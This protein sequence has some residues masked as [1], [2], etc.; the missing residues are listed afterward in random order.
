MNVD[1]NQYVIV[2]VTVGGLTYVTDLFQSVT[3]NYLGTYFLYNC[4][5]LPLVC[6]Y[7]IHFMLLLSV[8]LVNIVRLPLESPTLIDLSF[9]INIKID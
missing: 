6:S 9:R 5:S 1:I 3:N 7:T 2:T 4:Y 8:F